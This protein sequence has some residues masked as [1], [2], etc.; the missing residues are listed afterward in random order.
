MPGWEIGY[1][2]LVNNEWRYFQVGFMHVIDFHE[3]VLECGKRLL[4]FFILFI[5][6][7]DGSV[8]GDMFHEPGMYGQWGFYF[9]FALISYLCFISCFLSLD[10][11]GS[12]AVLGWKG[13]FI[14][15]W[16]GIC[17]YDAA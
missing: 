4:S 1:D 12:L 8:F 9:I 16:D 6:G 15:N 17:L 5:Y 11:A 14:L 10:V 13:L 7:W 2:R 3:Y